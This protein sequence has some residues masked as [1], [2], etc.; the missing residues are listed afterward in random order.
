MARHDRPLFVYG[1]LRFPEILRRLLGRVP[2][3]EPAAVPGWRAAALAG[4]P[5]PGLVPAPG[6]VAP[7]ILLT[8]L[9]AGEWAALDAF[10]GA[11]YV[12]REVALEDGRGVRAYVWRCGDVLAGDWD[13]AEFADRCLAAYAPEHR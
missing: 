3:A 6:A 2:P 1:T 13:A 7:G 5:Y 4:R 8:G 12:L 9:T 10:E 11:E